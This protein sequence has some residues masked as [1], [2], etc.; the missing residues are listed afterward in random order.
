MKYRA[1]AAY[2]AGGALFSI[3]ACAPHDASAS[4][5]KC[6]NPSLLH[7]D[8]ERLI[9]AARAV[10]PPHLEPTIADRCRWSDSAFAWIA[11]AKVTE[12]SG[13]THWWASNCSR[14]EW[15]WTCERAAFQEQFETSVF[16]DGMPRHLKINFDADTNLATVKLLSS[17]ALQLYANST[18]PI[19]YCSGMQ[20]QEAR[21]ALV[22]E[23]RP[24]PTGNEEL[25]ITVGRE[26][27]K[28]WVWFGDLMHPGDTQIG[29]AFPVPGTQSGQCW[30]A[31]QP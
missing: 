31:R 2:L 8:E 3:L 30:S 7:D 13:V 6:E 5:R 19:P 14:D 24:L 20:G 11:T 17:E 9:A 28:L 27:S 25:H 12:A 29:I 1:I 4:I 26:K 10:L 22:R 23:G 21:W 16:A 15:R 18:A